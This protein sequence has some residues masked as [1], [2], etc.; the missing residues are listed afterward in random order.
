MKV[1][2]FVSKL[3]FLKN[4]TYLTCTFLFT[5]SVFPA[6][7]LDIDMP[8]SLGELVFLELKTGKLPDDW[9]CAKV[10]VVT[11]ENHT[12]HFPWLSDDKVHYFR[13]EKGQLATH[14]L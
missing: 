9:F 10:T 13:E 3:S 6:N 8:T 5:F 14:T 2:P 4:K 11:P 7:S 1:V 12:A